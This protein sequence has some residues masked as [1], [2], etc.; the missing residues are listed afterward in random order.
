MPPGPIDHTDHTD[1]GD[2]L[3]RWASRVTGSVG[4]PSPVREVRWMDQ[5]HGSA[6][7]FAE[8]GVGGARSPAGSRQAVVALPAGPGDALVSVSPSVSL[9]V[10]TAD[11]ASIALGSGEG[12]FAAVHAGWRGLVLGVVEAAVAAMRTAGAT[13]VV[14]ALG[15]CIHPGCYEFSEDDLATVAGVY[16]DGVRG[17]TTAGRPALDIPAAVSAA[18]TA[19]GAT[20]TTGMDAC[21]AC[22]GGYFS[23]RARA[24]HGRQALLVWSSEDGAPA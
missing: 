18:L 15:P 17:S 16:G 5:V 12:V 9:A 21:T 19:G 24:D 10:L 3:G 20:E 8:A 11:C 22:A 1:R 13:E 7:L 2:R 14:G 6:V 4:G 23:H